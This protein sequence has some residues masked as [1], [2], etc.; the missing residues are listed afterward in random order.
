MEYHEGHFYRDR[1]GDIW[2]AGECDT[3]TFVA[4]GSGY[5]TVITNDTHSADRVNNEYGPLVEVQP[6]GW[7]TV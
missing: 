1:D 2:Q 3:L 7:E 6:T 5:R 4:H